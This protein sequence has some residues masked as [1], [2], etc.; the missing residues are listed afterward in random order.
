MR[1]LWRPVLVG[2]VIAVAV[3]ALAEAQIFAPSASSASAPSA[4][5]GDVQHGKA[6]FAATCA[7]CHGT[8]GAGGGAG[9]RLVG[10]GLSAA[11]VSNRVERGGGVMPAGLVQGQ[12]EAD[13]VAYVVSISGSG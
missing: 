11:E 9:P 2:C 6:V 4:A 1:A 12:D 5:S 8:A 13:V 3:F 7:G 10:T